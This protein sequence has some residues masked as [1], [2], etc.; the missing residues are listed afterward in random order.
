MV[1]LVPRIGFNDVFDSFYKDMNRRGFGSLMRTNIE[2]KDG[3]Y[4][5][6]IEL[7][8]YR[9]EDIKIDYTD[10]HLT[11]T[12]EK[13]QTQEEKDTKGNIIRQERV[14]GTVS[15][16]FYIGEDFEHENITA[17][18]ENGELK[19]YLPSKKPEEIVNKRLINIE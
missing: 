15:R 18:Y 5:L 1:R 19:V 17:K 10:G 6:D 9:K 4:L 16:S 12:A 7:P 8:G 3:N 14:M 2:E 11:I 13:N